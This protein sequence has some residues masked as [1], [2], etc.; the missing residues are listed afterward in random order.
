MTTIGHTAAPERAS[1]LPDPVCG[2]RVDPARASGRV[3]EHR[4][5]TFAFCSA[6]CRERFEA[7]PGRYLSGRDE[8]PSAGRTRDPGAAGHVVGDTEHAEPHSETSQ[9]PRGTE[10]TC[11]MHPEIAQGHPGDC[12]ICGM[13]LEPRGIPVEGESHEL[14]DTR[15]RL[16]WSLALGLPVFA[17]AMAEMIPGRPVS[18]VL[19]VQAQAW[20]QLAL[21]TPVV[22]WGGLPFFRKGW[23]SLATRH[24]NMY[25]LIALG[26]GA[27]FAYSVAATVAPGLFPE[28]LRGPEGAVPVYFEAAAV[29]TALVLLGQ[30]FELRARSRTSSALRAL[31]D[32]AP[33]SARIV[34]V[35]G[36]E[37][38][39]PLER[40]HV[41]D[42]LR[43]RPG[44]RVPVDG[45]VL[46]GR[47][48]VDESMLTGEALPVTKQAG[49]AV[50]GGTLNGA[51]SLILRAERVGSETLLS[52]I[53]GLVAEAQR[54]RAPIQR[55][56]DVVASWFVPVVIV[57]ALL[58][59]GAWL[60]FGP[61]PAFS[62]ALANAVAVL[63]IACPCALGLATPMSILVGTGRGA[64]AGVL[65]RDA[66]ALQA[67]ERVQVL[68]VD[69]TG[70]L[71][72]GKPRLKR[73]L[74]TG[75]YG[76][77]E[78]LTLAAS[79][80]RGSEHPLAG[81]V[82]AA[83]HE[84]G[85]ELLPLA[86]FTSVPGKG[87]QGRVGERAV[88]LG[89]EALL[90]ELG[91]RPMGLERQVAALRESGST[92]IYA[93]VD[94]ALAGAMGVAD[95]IKATTPEALRLLREE[96]LQ[97][98]MLSGDEPATA[99]AVG[100]DLGI[101]DVTAGVLPAEKDEFV[102]RLQARGYVVAM[103]G[104]GVNDAPALA[105]ADV[106]IAMGTGT[107][108]ALESAGVTLVKGDLMGIVR[109]RKLSRATMGNV[110]Q[111]LVFA[112]L[113]NALGV[114]V[115]AGA[116]YPFF[117]L[118]LDPMLASAAMS[119]SSI[120]VVLNALRLRKVTL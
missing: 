100:R 95:P 114:P 91:V 120:S 55:L 54:S 36:R 77:A 103:A 66:E 41:G 86:D 27:A 63:I 72:E 14:V 50:S 30:F 34:S 68:V 9:V 108:I 111:N 39:V 116:L 32:L 46:E 12:P 75:E 70:T 15:R 110:R 58:T 105:R 92:V 21:A 44:E 60:I 107:D 28:S 67:L 59:L 74:T 42:W 22:M 31:L 76:E 56:A 96:G 51:G 85:L 40:V 47:S 93:L 82:L 109:A 87:V 94:G 80:E 35:D 113:Y 106:G 64:A 52:R 26:V 83:A 61:A 19:S 81:A 73:V 7:E 99:A 112:F 33:P 38:D 78:L 97:V 89:N 69:K 11:P 25:T 13:A 118:L 98:V 10:Y 6:G 48:H 45:V 101:V 8:G 17:L 24:L 20:L 4:G 115:A 1:L 23:A 2:M 88:A 37:Q 49:D 104:D 102:R 29:I 3:L 119:L 90:A 79:L 117:G 5:A 65:I 18:R 84:R 57:I 43:V 62:F 53:V 71:T 16:G